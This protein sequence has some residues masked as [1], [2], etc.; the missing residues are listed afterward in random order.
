[1]LEIHNTEMEERNSDD[2]WNDTLVTLYPSFPPFRFKHVH[3]NPS[4][5]VYRP[6]FSS[7]VLLSVASQGLNIKN[8][9]IQ[10]IQA[11]S[12]TCSSRVLSLSTDSTAWRFEAAARAC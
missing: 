3:P 9:T 8:S 10:F 2:I 12:V 7:K 1:V 4:L 6:I 5:P 11:T